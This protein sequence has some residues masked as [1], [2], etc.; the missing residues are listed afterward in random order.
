MCVTTDHTGGGGGTSAVEA[1]LQRIVK[2][3]VVV[4]RPRQEGGRDGRPCGRGDVEE[5]VAGGAG[6][7]AAEGRRRDAGEVD[8][9]REARLLQSLLRHGEGLQLLLSVGHVGVLA[10]TADTVQTRLGQ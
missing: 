10:A 6:G 7:R 8:S 4:P 9:Q 2:R 1:H 3:P 5:G